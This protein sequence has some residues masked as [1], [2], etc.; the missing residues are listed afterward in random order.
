MK[1][2]AVGFDYG[3]VL[4]GRPS[5]ILSKEI[6][7]LLHTSEERYQDIY[8]NHNERFNRGEIS[9][10]ELWVIILDEL[11]QPDKLDI[12]LKFLNSSVYKSINQ[13]NLEL[14]DKL[15]A[16][17]IKVGLLS[18]NTQGEANRL[19]QEGIDKHFD[20]MHISAETGFTKPGRK[21]FEHFAHDLN[22]SLSE[23]IFIDDSKKSLSTASEL[24]Y[25]PIFYQNYNGL[26][27]RLAE[28]K[29]F[30]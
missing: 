8:Y 16:Q 12:I 20:I 23:L 1:Y 6:A 2:K 10:K 5:S 28:L 14:V 30:D 18:N 21:A 27:K 25:L 3:G 22:V 11:G 29:V 4:A 15:K 19:R 7:A 24:G 26:T 9:G 17:G 13:Q